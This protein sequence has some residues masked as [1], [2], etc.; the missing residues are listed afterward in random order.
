MA[1]VGKE[2]FGVAP[3]QGSVEKWTLRT[4]SVC[5][6]VISLG[7]IITAIKTPDRHGHLEDVVLGFDD[8]ES[9]S[10]LAVFAARCLVLLLV[11]EQR[12]F[13][14]TVTLCLLRS[15]NCP[16]N[17]TPVLH[18]RIERQQLCAN[19]KF[20]SLLSPGVEECWSNELCTVRSHMIDR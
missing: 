3:N 14:V 8:L 16:H 12:S 4:E 13:T 17:V 5:V 11:D 6:E 2:V 7:C 1:E 9:E 18:T 15:R 20:R 19:K 10:G